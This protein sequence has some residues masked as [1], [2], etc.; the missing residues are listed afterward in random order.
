[1]VRALLITGFL[2]GAAALAQ[3]PSPTPPDTPVRLQ[4]VNGQLSDVVKF[5]QHLTKR[6]VWLDAE[7]RFD[8]KMSLVSDRVIRALRRSV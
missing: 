3:S 7:L 5:Y 6:K 2:L 4:L 8:R 1:M